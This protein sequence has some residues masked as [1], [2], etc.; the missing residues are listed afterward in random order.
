MA[1]I[2]RT[3]FLIFIGVLIAVIGAS[4][5]VLL[6]T[7][8]QSKVESDTLVPLAARVDKIDGTVGIDNQLSD[9]TTSQAVSQVAH[10][11]QTPA[12]PLATNDGSATASGPAGDQAAAANQAAASADWVTPSVNTPLSV[13]QRVYVH[14]RSHLGVAFSGRN[15]VRLNPN[16]ELDVL[17]LAERRT[18]LALREGSG[19][20]DIGALA[21]GELCEVDT[22]YGAVD[23]DQPGLYQVGIEDNDA[24][25]TVLSGQAQVVGVDGTAP[26]NRGQELTLSGADDQAYVAD[27]APDVCGGIVNDYYGYRYPSD[28]DGRYADYNTYLSDPYYYDP[29]RRS[30]SYHYV[31]DEEDIAGLNDLDNY[32]DWD[33]VPGYG[34]CWHPHVDAGWAPYQSGYW[35]ND[36]PIGLTCVSSERWGWAPYHYCSLAS[37]NGVW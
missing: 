14:D 5:A 18:Q 2:R 29:Y 7:R 30:V 35:L 23:F 33:D 31:A 22:P 37:V 28:Y 4:A 34:Q 24:L 20:F 13:G 36:Y 10:G 17:S 3:W 8:A 21:P 25:V 26:C 19:V 6:A 11:N 16:T 15:Y 9:Q 32:G 1:I 12:N 27:V